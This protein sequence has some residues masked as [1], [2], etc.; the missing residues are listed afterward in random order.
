M[1]LWICSG[2]WSLLALVAPKHTAAN[3]LHYL[4]LHPMSPAK[5]SCLSCPQ[6][7]W[8]TPFATPVVPCS[9]PALLL[10]SFLPSGAFSWPFTLET[11]VL[12]L[13]WDNLKSLPEW[14]EYFFLRW[15]TECVGSSGWGGSGKITWAPKTLKF[16]EN[17]LLLRYID[18]FRILLFF[19]KKK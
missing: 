7:L 14:E 3:G 10:Q 2:C 15:C 11:N 9:S 16:Y 4:A 12:K 1:L 5:P 6:L 13:Y 17:G 8:V 19:K 18:P